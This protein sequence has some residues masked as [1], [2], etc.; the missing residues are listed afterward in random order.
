MAAILV[1]D[2]RSRII[3]TYGS[4]LAREVS[5]ISKY[6]V[7]RH[8]AYGWVR[9]LRF[10][11]Y[12]D[13][14]DGE[15]EKEQNRGPA[16]EGEGENKEKE[17]VEEN[18][19]QQAIALS[20][21]AEQ[22]K[23][24]RSGIRLESAVNQSIAEPEFENEQEMLDYAMAMSLQESQEVPH[25]KNK[26]SSAHRKENK[27]SVKSGHLRSCDTQTISAI[28]SLQVANEVSSS[29]NQARRPYK[30]PDVRPLCRC[31]L[32]LAVGQHWYVLGS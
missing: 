14:D 10:L 23:N 3:G 19:T 15:D 4:A 12:G 24:L 9:N 30:C 1:D 20:L 6:Q 28:S 29:A 16:S 32:L 2:T 17:E 21:A 7:N 26:T 8:N 22:R 13:E 5:E 31:P 18:Q 27:K 25:E 11:V